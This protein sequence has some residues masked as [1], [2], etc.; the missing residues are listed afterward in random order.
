MKEGKGQKQG[1][2]LGA[3]ALIQGGDDGSL[4]DGGGGEKWLSV[5]YI[6]KTDTTRFADW[7]NTGYKKEK[8][9]AQFQTRHILD[10]Y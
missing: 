8:P 9:E 7:L 5:G 2:Q 3:I 4:W 6:L 10:V 1:G